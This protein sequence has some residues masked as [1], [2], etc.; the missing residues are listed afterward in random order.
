MS[1]RKDIDKEKDVQKLKKKTG[2]VY[3]GVRANSF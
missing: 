2:D 1:E 3:M